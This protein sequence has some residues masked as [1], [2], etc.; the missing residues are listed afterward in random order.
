MNKCVVFLFSQKKRSINALP[1]G[2]LNFDTAVKLISDT[3][4]I[5]WSFRRSVK[6]MCVSFASLIKMQQIQS[7]Q[8][9]WTK[10]QNG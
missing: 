10:R 1:F 8:L 7:H 5:F 9:H 6:F 2:S 3:S 4:A